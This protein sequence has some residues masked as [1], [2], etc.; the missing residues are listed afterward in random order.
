[1]QAKRLLDYSANNIDNLIVGK[2]MGLTALGF[3]DKAF[4]TMNRFLLR[5]NTGGPTTMFRIFA[6]MQDDYDR[7]RRAYRRVILSACV[8]GFPLLAILVTSAPALMV[9]LF[10]G[11]WLPAAAPF[12]ILG[13][14]GMFR[15]VNSY[16]SS[17]IQAFGKVWLE[18][19]SQLV[20]V[21]LIA[22]GVYLARGRGVQGAAEAVFV[23]TA[24]M[25]LLMHGVL[26]RVTGLSWNEI[27][28]PLVPGLVC[29]AGAA[30]VALVAEAG[31]RRV[32]GP[33][34]PLVS[35]AVQMSVGG[36]WSVLFLVT[37]PH[38]EMRE[39]VGETVRDLM[40]LPLRQ[41][42]WLQRWLPEPG[43]KMSPVP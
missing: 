28:G 29:A 38:S 19:V 11:N 42:P 9:V 22:G 39:L 8:F 24:V 36:A 17:A 16:A 34:P 25:S 43:A 31:C 7:F 10:G 35:L 30:T 33:L 32:F 26:R 6:L 18:V 13:I 4:S 2:V 23:A 14:A 40:P 1:M 41:H 20:Y 3:Y 27:L 21:A 5:L 37:F 15:M 12:Q